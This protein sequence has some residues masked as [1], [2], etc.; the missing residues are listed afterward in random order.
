[1][2]TKGIHLLLVYRV[3]LRERLMIA[4]VDAGQYIGLVA[5]GRGIVRN[6]RGGRIG[7]FRFG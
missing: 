2:Q 3:K 5:F 4:S 7:R 6:T 1:M